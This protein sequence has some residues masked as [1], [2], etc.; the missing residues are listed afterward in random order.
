MSWSRLLPTSCRASQ[1]AAALAGDLVVVA[2]AWVPLALAGVGASATATAVAVSAAQGAI[3]LVNVVL[4]TREDMVVPPVWRGCRPVRRHRPTRKPPRLLP[5]GRLSGDVP[6]LRPAYLDG[7]RGALARAGIPARPGSHRDLRL[8]VS[9]GVRP[10]SPARGD[11]AAIA[12]R[13]SVAV[14]RSRA[15]QRSR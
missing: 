15:I 4:R 14:N 12:P 3:R 13:H 11:C 10:A 8:R 6:R 2:D 1:P 5:R 7:C 9:A